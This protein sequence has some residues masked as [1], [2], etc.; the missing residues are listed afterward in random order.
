MQVRLQNIITHEFCLALPAITGF[1]DT[2]TR[3]SRLLLLCNLDFA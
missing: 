3:V 2:V 1:S